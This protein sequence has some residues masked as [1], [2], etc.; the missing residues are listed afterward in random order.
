MFEVFSTILNPPYEVHVLTNYGIFVLDF[1]Y[2][3]TDMLLSFNNFTHRIIRFHSN[4]EGKISYNAMQAVN[5][6]GYSFLIRIHNSTTDFNLYVGFVSFYSNYNA[7]LVKIQ[8][9]ERNKVCSSLNLLY[10]TPI[11]ILDQISIS[12][13][14]DT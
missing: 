8:Y 12:L 4:I 6:W 14:C 5:G 7:Q 13:V 9:I 11:P 1:D 3:T 10:T 2:N